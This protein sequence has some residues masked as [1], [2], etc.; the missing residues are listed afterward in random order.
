MGRVRGWEKRIKMREKYKDGGCVSGWRERLLML[1][2]CQ[3]GMESIR[4]KGY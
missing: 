2:L 3:D 1:G 4:I